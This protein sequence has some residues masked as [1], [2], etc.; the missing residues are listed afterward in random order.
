MDIVKVGAAL[1]GLDTARI[2]RA[3]KTRWMEKTFPVGADYRDEVARFDRLYLV[4]DPWSLD[5]RASEKTRFRRT[6]RLILDNFGHAR[7]LLEI[8]CGEGLQSSHLQQVCDRLHGVDVSARAVRRATRRCPHG[9]F[10]VGDMYCLPQRFPP[11]QFDLVI[12]CEVLYYMSDIPRALRRLSELG[13]TC[14]ISYYDGARE[15]LD[16][17]VRELPGVQFEIVSCE[18]VSWTLVSW[19]L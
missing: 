11:P 17:Y 5:Q 8:G 14:V 4:R 18:D 13:R 12:A 7:S 15:V 6:N 19:R 3:L 10:G 2:T 16:K 1:L 9:I